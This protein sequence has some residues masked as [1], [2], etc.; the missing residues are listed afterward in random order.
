M[1]VQR[2]D[3]NPP[4]PIGAKVHGIGATRVL[5]VTGWD[6]Y[7]SWGK[8]FVRVE[9]GNVDDE[10][11]REYALMHQWELELATYD[12]GRAEALRE[13]RGAVAALP[14]GGMGLRAH[15]LWRNALAAIY[16]LGGQS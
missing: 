16:A 3:R 8:W 9:T 12:A 11:E 5:T 7:P 10:G 15:E 4:F 14:K 13:A 6:F 1:S 2:T